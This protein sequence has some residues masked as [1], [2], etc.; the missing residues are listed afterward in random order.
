MSVQRWR[1]WKMFHSNVGRNE[2]HL[3]ERRWS[4][5]L[6]NALMLFNFLFYWMWL[7]LQQSSHVYLSLS[8][9]A[10]VEQK[11]KNRFCVSQIKSVPCHEFHNI[12]LIIW[13]LVF[14]T[15]HATVNVVCGEWPFAALHLCP[16]VLG[17]LLTLNDCNRGTPICTYR[18]WI[19][20]H[21]AQYQLLNNVDH[22]DTT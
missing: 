10:F 22:Q 14:I 9:R 20:L 4:I 8:L 19:E 21:Q 2:K 13:M 1:L 17:K 3:S 6:L 16:S 7:R 12:Y 18:I 11:S 5:G 15:H